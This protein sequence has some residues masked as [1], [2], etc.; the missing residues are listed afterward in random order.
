MSNNTATQAAHPWRA[1]TRTVFAALIGLASMWALIV[2]TLGLDPGIPWVAASIAVTGA[3]TRVLALP[4]V[5]AWLERYVPW[6]A[7]GDR[8]SG[9]DE[10]SL[11]Q[12]THYGDLRDDLDS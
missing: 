7:P 4:G 11:A 8:S 2:E 1:T 9:D 5:I 6:L 10:W 3:V 12:N